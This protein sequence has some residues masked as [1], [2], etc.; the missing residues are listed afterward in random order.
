MRCFK[1]LT[2][3]DSDQNNKTT[4]EGLERTRVERRWFIVG[5]DVGESEGEETSR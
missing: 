3:R 1:G 2:K 4:T 5:C